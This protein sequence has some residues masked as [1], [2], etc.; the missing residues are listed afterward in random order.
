[1]VTLTC[2]NRCAVRRARQIWSWLPLERLN[3][4]INRRTGVVGAFPTPAPWCMI[5]LAHRNCITLLLTEPGQVAIPEPAAAK[6]KPAHPPGV[7]DL[8]SSRPSPSG[9]G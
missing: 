5:L 2:G 1:M 8:P 6:L 3:N 4:E 7:G 9:G